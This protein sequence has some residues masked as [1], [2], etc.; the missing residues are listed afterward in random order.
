VN[1]KFKVKNSDR[2]TMIFYARFSA[3]FERE[4]KRPTMLLQYSYTFAQD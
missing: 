4:K 3:L 2:K 1:N